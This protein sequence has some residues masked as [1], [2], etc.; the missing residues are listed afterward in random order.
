MQPSVL[1]V[2]TQAAHRSLMK[3]IL[4]AEP[5][6]VFEAAT[7]HEAFQLI[8]DNSID[9]VIADF[10]LCQI[11]GF[12]LCRKIKS[13][14]RHRLIQLLVL[15]N[16]H[17]GEA[18]MRALEAGADDFMAR[19]IQPVVFR[20]RLRASLRC[21]RTMDSLEEAESIIF[22]LAR[23]V[24]HRDHTTGSHCERLAVF[25]QALG[26]TLGLCD[27]DLIALQRGSYLHDI[28]KICVPDSILHKEGPLTSEEWAIMREHTIQGEAICRPMRTLAPVLP[29]IRSHHERWDGSGYP[30]GL[31]GEDI[32]LLARILQIADVF[33][34][35]TS[36]R[37]YKPAYSLED[38]ANVLHEEAVR[39]WRD[40]DLVAAFVSLINRPGGIAITMGDDAIDPIAQVHQSDLANLGESLS[41][42]DEAT[43]GK[44]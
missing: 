38:A 35:L 15:A 16:R 21:K 34:A 43:A 14:R 22:T 9:L 18:E 25:S 28:G 4:K 6:R 12:D 13:H 20:T 42:L 29:I 44:P 31:A 5:Y 23:V 1:I 7:A 37:S 41:R 19:P 26:R 10:G 17:S 8:E 33:D 39:G 2:D 32:P 3:G 30:D 36:R 40:R 24:E 27:D 11:D